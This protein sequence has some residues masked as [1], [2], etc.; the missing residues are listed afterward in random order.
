VEA[1]LEPARAL[2]PDL[3]LDDLRLGGSG[4]RPKLHGPEIS[5]ADFMIKRD[6]HEPRLIQASGIESPGLTACLSIGEHVASLVG[7]VLG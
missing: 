2:L 1:F 7:E 4:I 5:F 6:A 3:T